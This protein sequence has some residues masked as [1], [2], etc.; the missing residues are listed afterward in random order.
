MLRKVLEEY[1]LHIKNFRKNFVV[2]NEIIS[3]LKRNQISRYY[4]YEGDLIR[5][6]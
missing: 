4:Q 2:N 5:K 6:K 3:L 1:L